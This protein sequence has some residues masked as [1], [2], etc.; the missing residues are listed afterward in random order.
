MRIWAVSDLHIADDSHLGALDQFVTLARRH[1]PDILVLNGDIGDP[2]KVAWPQVL[3][4]ESWWKLCHLVHNRVE[5]STIWIPEN[6]D[7][8]AKSKYLPGATLVHGRYDVGDYTFMHGWQFDISWNLIH[9]FCFWLSEKYPKLAVTLYQQL[10]GKHTPSKLKYGNSPVAKPEEWNEH[11]GIIHLRARSW[12]KRNNR[13][14]LIGHTHCPTPFDGLIADSG[15]F[16]DS[17]SWLEIE[18]NEVRLLGL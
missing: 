7:Y 14:L 18:D 12:A 8:S 13:R 3:E 6:H 5:Q 16:L 17:F 4:T 11:V 9:R 15:D 10:Y 1:Q 2:W